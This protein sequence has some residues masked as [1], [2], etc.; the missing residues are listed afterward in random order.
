MLF[1]QRKIN[2]SLVVMLMVS[3]ALALV[4]GGCQQ[5]AA[6]QKEA[7]APKT[8]NQNIRIMMG[9][10][11]GTLYPLG[12][13]IADIMLANFPNMKAN[14]A[15]GAAISNLVAI[16]ANNAQMGHT[17][18]DVAAMAWA[19]KEPFK[20]KLG[21]VRGF[22]KVMDQPV[23]FVVAADSP[24]K[25]IKDIKDKKYPLK[26]AVNPPG[27]ASEL[28]VRKL[29]ETYGIT[30]QDIE[31]WGGKVHKVSHSDMVSLYKDRHAEAMFLYT[32]LPSPIFV[33]CSMTKPL[34]LLPLK[35]EGLKMLQEVFGMEAFTVPKDTYK[36][37]TEDTQ[38]VRGGLFLA[39]NKDMPEDLIYNLTKAL[40]KP[41][42]LE[43]LKKVHAD[44]DK[45]LA[46]PKRAA[47]G[48][49]IPLHPGVEKYYRE[50]GWIK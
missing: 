2:K 36:G 37:M 8:E 47:G 14:V 38:I 22:M 29:L 9:P 44:Y 45:F 7:Q 24:I 48:M 40:F 43:R 49:P 4:L 39:V 10:M 5:S 32:A 18:S 33:E 30:Y 21:N 15:P 25:S 16:D 3:L 26:L 34:R 50:V 46:T 28:I 19:G 41:E 12:A 6:P 11:G 35:G 42:N 20:Q 31:S 13:T 27:N 23:Q 17:T 1:R